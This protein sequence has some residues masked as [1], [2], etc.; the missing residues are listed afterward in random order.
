MLQG[1]KSFSEAFEESE[2]TS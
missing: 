1:A 2:N